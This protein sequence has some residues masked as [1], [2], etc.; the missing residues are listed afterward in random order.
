MRFLIPAIVSLFGP[1]VPQV[2]HFSKGEHKEIDT[3]QKVAPFYKGKYQKTPADTRCCA[4]GCCARGVFCQGVA[5]GKETDTAPISAQPTASRFSA[6]IW[7][8]QFRLVFVRRQIKYV[9]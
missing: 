9:S 6:R 7:L 5:R 1:E 3:H 2:S 8:H 4:L